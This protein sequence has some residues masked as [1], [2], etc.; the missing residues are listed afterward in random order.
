MQKNYSIYVGQIKGTVTALS[1][2]TGIFT[3]FL[4]NNKI[5][6]RIQHF[7]LI[8]ICMWVCYYIPPIRHYFFPK[9]VTREVTQRKEFSQNLTFGTMF[10]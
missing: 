9:A 6:I 4:I 2:D 5:I 7:D 8:T 10:K 1:R 3:N